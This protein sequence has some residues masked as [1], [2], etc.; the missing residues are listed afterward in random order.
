MDNNFQFHFIEPDQNISDFVENLG[1][2]YNRSDRSK[3]V[4]IPDGRG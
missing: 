2:F 4:I 3:E 1:T